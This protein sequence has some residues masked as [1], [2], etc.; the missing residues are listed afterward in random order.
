MHVTSSMRF[1]AAFAAALLLAT[2]LAACG[3]GGSGSSSSRGDKSSSS[4]SPTPATL[5]VTKLTW[6]PESTPPDTGNLNAAATYNDVIVVVGVDSKTS[7]GAVWTTHDGKTW[8]TA[9]VDTTVFPA[10]EY[11]FAV[12]A[13]D[14]LVVIAGT[15]D[16]GAGGLPVAWSSTDLKTWKRV[17]LGLGPGA[18]GVLDALSSGPKGFSAVLTQSS[19]TGLPSKNL[20]VTSADGADWSVETNPIAM[21]DPGASI[22][23]VEQTDS[24]YLAVGS[25]TKPGSSNATDAATWTSSDGT[26]WTR[27]TSKSLVTP[28]YESINDV[29]A[30]GPGFVAVGT[31]DTGKEQP[32][33]WTSTDGSD[34]T[35]ASQG[36]EFLGQGGGGIS[37]V[38]ATD[39]GLIATGQS[40]GTGNKAVSAWVSPDGKSWTVQ[41]VAPAPG[42]T[43][44]TVTGLAV[45]SG[46][47]VVLT[48]LQTFDVS[49]GGFKT[50]GLASYP[51]A[52][53]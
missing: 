41:H 17:D 22:N 42:D 9:D 18:T 35:V 37:R 1:S 19:G 43:I 14:D 34:W 49:A 39:S 36:K 31:R 6:Q 32:T 51:G 40:G 38:L 52:A 30:G 20:L 29:T 53:S 27:S 11:P 2:P 13:T 24:G 12:A 15:K 47:A 45:A 33:V 48:R 4:T 16:D 25:Y 50:V 28:Q 10:K 26:S 7:G 21:K 3:S 46:G 8:T 23:D 44:P 5:D